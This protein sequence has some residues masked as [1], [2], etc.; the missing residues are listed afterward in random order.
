MDEQKSLWTSLW[1]EWVQPSREQEG[2]TRWGTGT[3]PRVTL[4]QK[5]QLS[6][7][8]KGEAELGREPRLRRGQKYT[9]I[10]ALGRQS[11]V[12]L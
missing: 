3:D 7:E 9:E 5:P 6:G 8:M 11:P 4:S 1:T 10:Q 2:G 12:L